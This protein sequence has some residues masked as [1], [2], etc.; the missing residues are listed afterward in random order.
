MSCSSGVVVYLASWEN[1]SMLNVLQGSL[2]KD[3][4]R[5]IGDVMHGFCQLVYPFF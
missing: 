2:G 4:K 5:V 1:V 3:A